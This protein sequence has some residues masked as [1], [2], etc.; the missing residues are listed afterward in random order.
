MKNDPFH[1]TYRFGYFSE[2]DVYFAEFI[3]GLGE[4][5]DSHVKLAAA[6]VSKAVASGSICVD[7]SH[8]AAMSPTLP[9]GEISTA[10]YPDLDQWESALGNHPAVGPPAS[11]HPLILDDRHR[12]YLFRYWEYE[13]K[14]ALNIQN[15]VQQVVAEDDIDINLLKDGLRRYFPVKAEQGVDWQKVAG[16]ASVLKRF[17][18]ITGGPGT[19]KT[20]TVARI[21][22]L[23]LEQADGN[24]SI[25]LTAP[26]GKAAAK[27]GDTLRRSRDSLECRQSIRDAIPLE[28]STIHRLLGPMAGSPYFRYNVDHRLD[29][30]LVIVD[31][32]SMVDLALMSKLVQALP[33]Q[34]RLILIGDKDQL[35]SVEAG[36]VLG[37]ICDRN[38]LHPYSVSFT[39]Q[40]KR[41]SGETL[42]SDP[43]I[44][45]VDPGI[46]D[47]IIHLMT[48]YRF[49]D[50][51]GLDEFGAAVNLGNTNEAIRTLE[52]TRTDSDLQWHSVGSIRELQRGLKE[53]IVRGY[54]P[55]LSAGDPG[56]ALAHFGRFRLLCAVKKGPF[57][58]A[59]MNR[60]IE[61]VLRERRLIR[62]DKKYGHWYAGR[63]VMVTRNLYEL[64]LYNGDTGIALKDT[65]SGDPYLKVFFPDN[66]Y[67]FKKI[68]VNRL[69]DCETAFATTV[70]KSQGSEY[71]SLHFILPG[72]DATV[73][74]RE[75]IY[76]AVTRARRVVTIWGDR[77]VLNTAIE[78]QIDRNSGLRD[79][80]WSSPK[81]KDSPNKP[82]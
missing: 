8:L 43:Q 49:G 81:G 68:P 75:L 31:E 23:N 64:G 48:N 29:V 38:R 74:T 33:D 6:L 35:A 63:P 56:R 1:Q 47:N 21:L 16:L 19:G 46:Q 71:E 5:S 7:L 26:T 77:Q 80:L 79:M 65:E 39:E 52:D 12:L 67:V 50:R 24:L 59:E 76:T 28:T 10:R 53:T 44:S 62:N 69:T 20:F 9:N 60:Y 2:M 55:Y 18:V 3:D 27:L 42:V 37:D 57:G 66:D 45:A 73:L 58:V 41:I 32:A 4:K 82:H 34:A 25:A 14:L 30:D 17:C 72:K 36:A 13:S 51:C 70:H 40:V 15:R 61:S 78:R 22:A 11:R 54:G